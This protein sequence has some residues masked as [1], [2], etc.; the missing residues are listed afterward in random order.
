M[1]TD[2]NKDIIS[3][4]K[5]EDIH[6]FLR[7]RMGVDI[8]MH[9]GHKDGCCMCR[10]HD[11]IR[12]NRPEVN[13]R[14]YPCIYLHAVVVSID[15]V[16]SVYKHEGSIDFTIGSQKKSNRNLRCILVGIKMEEDLLEKVNYQ[17]E[18]ANSNKL[19]CVDTEVRD[20]TKIFGV[21]NPLFI[22]RLFFKQEY[23]K[24]P[25]FTPH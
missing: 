23:P 14:Y 13:I 20:M 2:L 4:W 7:N 21:C 3:Q 12:M 5:F 1:Q 18:I 11:Y 24:I 22:S 19:T 10:T 25:D 17:K 15:E 8:A 6:K 16:Q 9:V